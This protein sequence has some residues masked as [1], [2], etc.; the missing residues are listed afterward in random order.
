MTQDSVAAVPARDAPASET[1]MWKELFGKE[2]WWAIWVGLG[3]VLVAYALYASGTSIKWIAVTPAKWSHL[4]QLHTHFATNALRYAAQ[5]IMWA[6]V[7]SIAV[8]ALGY[9]AKDFLLS[10]LLVYVLSVL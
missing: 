1:P 8:E 9:R 6:S 4:D 3:I 7:F 10:F 2:D 5:F